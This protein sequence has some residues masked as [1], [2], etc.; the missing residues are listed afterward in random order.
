MRL[1]LQLEKLKKDNRKRKKILKKFK[2]RGERKRDIQRKRERQ[3]E[4]KIVR[5]NE[6]DKEEKGG[7][8][9]DKKKERKIDRKKLKKGK[10]QFLSI[11]IN[12][13]YEVPKEIS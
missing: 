13:S 11:P 12:L 7:G 5:K 10:I 4:R 3:R 9:I 8:K 1:K 6:R 2:E